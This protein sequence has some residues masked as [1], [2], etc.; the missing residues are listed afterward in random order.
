MQNVFL[1]S[2]YYHWKS[3][4]YLKNNRNHEN[5]FIFFVVPFFLG[6]CDWRCG[7]HLLPAAAVHPAHQLEERGMYGCMYVWMYYLYVCIYG[8]YVCMLMD[9][10]RLCWTIFWRMNFRLRLICL[11]KAIDVY[12]CM[13][14]WSSLPLFRFFVGIVSAGR[15]GGIVLRTN[16]HIY[17]S[18]GEPMVYV[19]M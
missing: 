15:A 7:V 14:V 4:S 1:Y 6:R 11:D 12:V 10:Y 3:L 16:Y 19:C 18:Q 17:I 13:Y 2:T 8:L 9:I 5:I